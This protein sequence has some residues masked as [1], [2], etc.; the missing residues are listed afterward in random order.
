M[1]IRRTFPALRCA[2]GEWVYYVTYFRF[3]DVAD[4]IKPTDEIHSSKKLA[5][6]IQ[7]R[8][9]KAHAAR[10]AK[11]LSKQA[12]HFFSALVV[13]IYGGQPKWAELRISDPRDELTDGEEIELQKSIGFLRLSGTEKLFAI[14]GQHRVAGIKKAV[15]EKEGNS[16]DEIAVIFVG[17]QNTPPGLA[18]TR[19]LFTTLN[20][21]A[22]KVSAADIVALDEDN[23]FA[24]VARRL[25][26]ECEVFSTR[27]IVS[28][29]GSSALKETDHNSV[30]SVIGLY[31]LVRDLYPRK[32]AGWPLRSVAAKTRAN[33]HV[34]DQIF[35]LNTQYWRALV[36]HFQEYRQV[37]VKGTSKAIDHRNHLLFRPVGQRAFAGA[38]Q[39]LME[40]KLTI[41]KAITLL[42]KVN[43][44]LTAPMWHY[45]LWDPLQK[46]ILWKNRI[47][48][49]SLL[50]IEA[51]Q[52][53]RDDASAELL[54][55]ILANRGQMKG[56]TGP[57]FGKIAEPRQKSR[58]G[59]SDHE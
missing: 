31:E 1:S 35:D 10:I 18:R 55:T 5:K 15:E 13:G 24:V 21:T 38:V 36:D 52:S 34:I 25:V 54:R 3:C 39:V 41:S 9:D 23:T 27:E 33:D 8:L 42:R 19:R 14:D 59:K 48:A 46:L 45:I 43:L 44:D 32:R 4:W 30:T 47:P 22:K 16:D 17:H 12:E 26:D 29:S 40:R 56:G 50:L 20:K 57:G 53:P 11:Y 7:R 6:W 49:E 37:I 2:M 28:F 51:G 58:K